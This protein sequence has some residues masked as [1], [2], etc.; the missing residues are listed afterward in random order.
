MADR[1]APAVKVHDKSLP[2]RRE[3]HHVF[4]VKHLKNSN[5]WRYWGCKENRQLA[6]EARTGWV[7]SGQASLAWVWNGGT[8]G[9]AALRLSLRVE[10]G[11]E[12]TFHAC[13]QIF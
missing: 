10:V 8:R 11:Y 12:F 3:K 9:P 5:L 1:F 2:A 4:L 7:S 13:D 6:R